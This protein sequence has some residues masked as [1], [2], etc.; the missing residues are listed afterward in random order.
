MDAAMI[1]LKDAANDHW[2]IK[3][4]TARQQIKN[5]R[6]SAD[7]NG[8]RDWWVSLGEVRRYARE[9]QGREI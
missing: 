6:I 7:K 1:L 5:K 3:P 9:S 2:H 8:G 4:A